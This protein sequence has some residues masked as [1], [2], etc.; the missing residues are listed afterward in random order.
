MVNDEI[1]EEFFE[2]FGGVRDFTN[3]FW[4]ILR[5]LLKKILICEIIFFPK[6]CGLVFVF[7]SFIIFHILFSFSSICTCQKIIEIFIFFYFMD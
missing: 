5:V 3:D 6:F 4:K 1:Y 2:K 7:Y